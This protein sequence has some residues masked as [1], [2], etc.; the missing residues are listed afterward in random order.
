MRYGWYQ[1]GGGKWY[2]LNTLHDGSFGKMLT[3]WH[4]IDG[5]SYC[6]G[7]DGSLYQDTVTPDGYMVNKDGR[8]IKDF[9]VQYIKG[10]G[11]SLTQRLASK[12]KTLKYNI[13]KA[14][15][16]PHCRRQIRKKV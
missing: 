13:L 12:A 4:W 10:K 16:C 8:W 2:F 11:G 1:D 7:N 5:Y 3:N 14:K 6:F 15:D 9:K